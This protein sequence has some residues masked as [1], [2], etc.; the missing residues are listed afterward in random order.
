MHQ[1]I[2]IALEIDYFCTK[3]LRSWERGANEI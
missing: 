1:E 3:S 2:A